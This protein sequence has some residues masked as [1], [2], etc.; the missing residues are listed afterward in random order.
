MCL[1]SFRQR[2]VQATRSTD[3]LRS[4]AKHEV[5]EQTRDIL[6]RTVAGGVIVNSGYGA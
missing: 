4:I 6:R 3:P 5:I 2:V 1:R